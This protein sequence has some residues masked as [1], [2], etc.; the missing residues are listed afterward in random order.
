[1]IVGPSVVRGGQCDIPT[2]IVRDRV[3]D[4][5]G[6]AR[7]QVDGVDVVNSVSGGDR[8]TGRTVDRA[9]DQMA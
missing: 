2:V 1:M 7:R 9:H 5:Q 4:C 3:V 8:D 6:T